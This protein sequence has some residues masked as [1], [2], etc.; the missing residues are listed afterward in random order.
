MSNLPP[1]KTRW[2][3]HDGT[4]TFFLPDHS[5]HTVPARDVDHSITLCI[6]FDLVAAM[7]PAERCFIASVTAAYGRHE[8]G[9]EDERARSAG[10]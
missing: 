4:A 9:E 2:G 10:G 6:I 8:R 5:Q 7:S 1:P 3:V